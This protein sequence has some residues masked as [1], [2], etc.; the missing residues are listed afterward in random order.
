MR[1]SSMD[2]SRARDLY[3]KLDIL[4]NVQSNVR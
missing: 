4:G 1:M 2:E 3:T